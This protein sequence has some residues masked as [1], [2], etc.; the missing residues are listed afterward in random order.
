MFD[1][2]VFQGLWLIEVDKQDLV[3]LL[4]I[5]EL[6]VEW[7]ECFIVFSDDFF[8]EV[9]DFGYKVLKSVFDGFIVGVLD[10]LLIYATFNCCYLML[11][12]MSEN[13]DIYCIG[14]EIYFGE[15]IEEKILFFECF[16]FWLFF[17][18]FDQDYYFVICW[19][20][21]CEFGIGVDLWDE[22]LCQEA[23]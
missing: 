17:Y 4:E 16:G 1:C 11:E 6:L 5:V 19:Y 13:F 23:L 20:W 15:I 9:S 21:L 12:Y 3:D 10:N 7:L 14:D 22:N 18:F 2:Y 8:F